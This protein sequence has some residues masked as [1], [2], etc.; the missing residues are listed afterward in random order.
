MKYLTKKGNI[1]WYRRRLNKSKEILI[2]LKTPDYNVAVLKHSLINY[3]VNYEISKGL[4][5]MSNKKAGSLIDKYKMYMIDNE[6]NE[7]TKMR[8]E[9]L[10]IHLNGKFYGGHTY[11]ALNKALT[12]HNEAYQSNDY[13]RVRI[14]AE[15]IINR[16]NI[17]DDVEK[18]QDS[19]RLYNL[20]W[21]LL[22]VESN[23]LQWARTKQLELE[24]E[25]GIIPDESVIDIDKYTLNRNN[26][27]S[28]SSKSYRI[29]E[30]HEK[31]MKEQAKA[32]AWSDKNIRDINYVIG[33]FQSWFDNCY[34]SSLERDAIVKFR[35]DVIY[36]LP[37][38]ITK[39]IYKGKSTQEIINIVKETKDETIGITTVNKHIGR[40][41]QLFEWASD[42]KYIPYNVFKRLR[43]KD[44]RDKKSVKLPYNDIELKNLFHD[45]PWFK[46]NL[47]DMLRNN[48]GYI[49]IPLL[50]LFNGGAK[51]IELAQLYVKDIK[52]VNGIWVIDFNNDDDKK[53]KAP[54]FNTRIIPIA[55]KILDLGFLDYV[56]HQKKQ[57]SLRLFPQITIYQ[58]GHSCFTNKF[59]QYNRDY[60][61]QDEKKTLYSIKHLVNQTLKNNKIDIYTINDITGHSGGSNNKDVSV[62]GDTSMPKI[63]MKEAIDKS[64]T[65]DYIDLSHIKKA[66]EEIY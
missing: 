33:L 48:P 35:D 20:H 22:K 50:S 27:I 54:N 13:D 65:F 53:L 57:K 15:K 44:K 12:E 21:K 66:I 36:N 14:K 4:K 29:S 49:F 3:F 42:T 11:I 37:T 26:F 9:E 6:I 1:Y 63:I 61:T 51:P 55:Q 41:H 19:D 58:S 24:R 59:S 17:K 16:S 60:V 32:N 5:K 8:D 18:I 10:S 62:Y 52:Q 38:K 47:K 28:A 39:N 30:L 56:K 45:S 2:S 7:Y 43:I 34:V 40:V 31:Y 46:E 23:L 25:M 64:L